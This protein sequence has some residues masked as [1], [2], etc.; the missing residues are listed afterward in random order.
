MCVHLCVWV[1]GGCLLKLLLSHE[2]FAT[3]F[4]QEQRRGRE[5][6]DLGHLV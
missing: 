3:A 5:E 4:Y 1:W 2:M 6:N